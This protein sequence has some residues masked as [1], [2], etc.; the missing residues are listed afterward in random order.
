[1][2]RGGENAKPE[3]EPRQGVCGADRHSGDC[4]DG[5]GLGADRVVFSVRQWMDHNRLHTLSLF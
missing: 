3:A 5:A 1:M 2:C 4:T